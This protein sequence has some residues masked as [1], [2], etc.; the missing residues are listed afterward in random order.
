[1][2]RNEQRYAQRHQIPEISF[3]P[4]QLIAEVGKIGNKLTDTRKGNNT[5]CSY[6][7]SQGRSVNSYGDW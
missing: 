5:Q 7:R 2:S 3:S 4:E 1:M 6:H